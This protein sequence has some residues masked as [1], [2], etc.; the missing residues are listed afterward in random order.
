MYRACLTGEAQRSCWR[1]CCAACCSAC[2]RASPWQ[3]SLFRRW[4][5]HAYMTKRAAS[6]TCRPHGDRPEPYSFLYFYSLCISK[7]QPLPHDDLQ[8]ALPCAWAATCAEAI[9]SVA[10]RLSGSTGSLLGS[11]RRRRCTHG[12]ARGL[13]RMQALRPGS[14][15]AQCLCSPS[16]WPTPSRL[17]G[18]HSKASVITQIAVFWL[19]E[20]PN[21][22]CA[23]DQS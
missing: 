1:A 2:M 16:S 17:S 11:W 7:A 19:G 23:S 14:G 18:R 13:P 20:P 5:R 3:R 21:C 8:A 4:S 9:D 15:S 22:V 12:S 10:G 6:Y